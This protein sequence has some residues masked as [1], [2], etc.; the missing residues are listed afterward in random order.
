MVGVKADSSKDEEGYVLTQTDADYVYDAD[1]AYGVLEMVDTLNDITELIFAQRRYLDGTKTTN[2]NG[3]LSSPFNNLA[4]ALSGITAYQMIIV[5]GTTPLTESSYSGST[6]I[7][8]GSDLTGPMFT[9]A[10]GVSTMLSWKT[11]TDRG[12]GTIVQ[13]NGGSLTLAGGVE[14]CHCDIAVDVVSGDVDLSQTIVE[15]ESYSIYMGA[16]SGALNMSAVAVTSVTGPIYLA[17]GKVITA[18]RALVCDLTVECES[19]AADV[20]VLKGSTYYSLSDADAERVSYADHDYGIKLNGNNQLVLMRYIYLDGTNLVNG[21][22][23]YASPYNSLTAAMSGIA[24]SSDIIR[25]IGTT[26]LS[27]N[28]DAAVTVQRDESLTGSMFSVSGTA[29]LSSM[30]IDGNGGGT[31]VTLD[32]G[33]LTLNS[34]VTLTNCNV[35]IDILGG[36]L[37]VIWAFID[38]AQYSVRLT[39]SDAVF[40]LNPASGRWPKISGTVYLATGKYINVGTPLARMA[41]P[42]TIECESPSVGTMVAYKTSGTFST[43]SEETQLVY[44]DSTYGITRADN[45]KQLVLTDPT[46]R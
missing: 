2:G 13:V 43:A 15:A 19:P 32:S 3:T 25:V 40:N 1:D 27:G 7:Q 28:Y 30:T 29:A 38:A 20:V 18:D 37:V 14:L 21:N 34:G 36:T 39:G 5:T 6:T 9:V 22:G 17:S 11:I 8:R 16:N 33:G 46:T 42:V 4:S 23:S 31:I 41:A 26:A 45:N 35:A 10:S 44:L 12:Q 24:V